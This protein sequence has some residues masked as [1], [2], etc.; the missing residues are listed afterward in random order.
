[1]LKRVTKGFIPFKGGT[2]CLEGDVCAENTYLL[3][4]TAT[5]MQK[6]IGAVISTTIPD[7]VATNQMLG[8]VSDRMSGDVTDRMSGDVSDRIL[9]DVPD[10]ILGNA[11]VL[12]EKMNW[13][14]LCQ[15]LKF[16]KPYCIV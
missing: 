5:M 6:I 12:A 8:D 2:P 14:A 15:G 10:R 13:K 9:G 7:I 4:M 3:M 11:V 1:M 16:I